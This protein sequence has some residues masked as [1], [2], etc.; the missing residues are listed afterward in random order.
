MMD[1]FVLS[2]SSDPRPSSLSSG[3][4]VA[5]DF[6]VRLTSVLTCPAWQTLKC[7]DQED[8][9]QADRVCACCLE[10]KKSLALKAIVK[11]SIKMTNIDEPTKNLIEDK[12]KLSSFGCKLKSSCK[13]QTAA[14]NKVKDVKVKKQR[15]LR[16]FLTFKRWKQRVFHFPI[17]PFPVLLAQ[18]V[19]LDRSS[20]SAPTRAAT[21]ATRAT[22]RHCKIVLCKIE[23]Q[24][25]TETH[26]M[27][28][29]KLWSNTRIK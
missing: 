1:V 28:S 9:S 29:I 27:I 21:R 17:S 26:Q 14:W 12:F 25:K 7:P 15:V 4:N 10:T 19:E 18:A 22:F 8:N 24:E 5:L 23:F 2:V 16:V 13:L 6:R 3:S 11:I 20:R